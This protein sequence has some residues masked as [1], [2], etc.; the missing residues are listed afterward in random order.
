MG[1]EVNAVHM[2]KGRAGREAT[3]RCGL[4]VNV[5]SSPIRLAGLTGWEH[6]VTCA[7][8]VLPSHARPVPPKDS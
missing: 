1:L 2:L 6:E 7:E 8:C 4:T 5:G 3:T